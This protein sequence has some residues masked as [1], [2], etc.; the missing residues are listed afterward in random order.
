MLFVILCWTESTRP[1]GMN[2][3]V[4]LGILCWTE[5]TSPI[6]ECITV[7]PCVSEMRIDVEIKSKIG[8]NNK[9]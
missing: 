4:P 1:K 3:G 9:K 8:Y 2:H 5:S 7:C 6:G